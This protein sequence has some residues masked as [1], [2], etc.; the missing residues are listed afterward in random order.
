MICWR[1][2]QANLQAVS[3]SGNVEIVQEIQV[4]FRSLLSRL[5]KL[6]GQWYPN[7][8]GNLG[9]LASNKEIQ[10]YFNTTQVYHSH[11]HHSL[12]SQ[13]LYI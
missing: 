12:L 8:P 9:N 13:F 3:I 11:I 7:G 10:P 5:P 2:A 6:P 4:V 1:Y